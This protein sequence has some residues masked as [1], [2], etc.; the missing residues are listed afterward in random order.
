MCIRVFPPGRVSTR[1]YSTASASKLNGLVGEIVWV[2][3]A[4]P[5]SGEEL[6]CC[7]V[8]LQHLAQG[9]CS[10]GYSCKGQQRYRKGADAPLASAGEYQGSKPGASA[11]VWCLTVEIWRLPKSG[12][13][14][15]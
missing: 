4:R 10:L 7:P 1:E 13:Y 15:T 12:Y 9:R 14:K 8:A 11:A 3:V 2:P 5:D 6:E